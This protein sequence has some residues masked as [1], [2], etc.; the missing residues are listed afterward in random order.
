[1]SRFLK[2]SLLLCLFSLLLCL[3]AFACSQTKQE[4]KPVVIPF[5]QDDLTQIYSLAFDSLLGPTERWI[6]EESSIVNDTAIVQYYYRLE[7]N[8]LFDDRI[9]SEK[10]YYGKGRKLLEKYEGFDQEQFK[11]IVADS[12]WKA[13]SYQKPT[14]LKSK[15]KYKLIPADISSLKESYHPGAT[16]AAVRLNKVAFNNTADNAIITISLHIAP[17]WGTEKAYFLRKKNGAWSI[18]GQNRLLIW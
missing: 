16:L 12:A 9:L 11:A 18:V 1:M 13:Y 8:D 2:Y 14:K 15:Y 4:E 3:F 17:D 5:T 7:T 6:D 10:R